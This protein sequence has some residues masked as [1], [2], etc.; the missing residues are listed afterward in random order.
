MNSGDGLKLAAGKAIN[1]HQ[2]IRRNTPTHAAMPDARKVEF[3]IKHKRVRLG[4]V[5]VEG[6]IGR[7][8]GSER[9]QSWLTFRRS[10]FFQLA[11]LIG[12][13]GVS[14]WYWGKWE[15]PAA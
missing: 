1:A 2:E 8:A 13:L 6:S 15:R 3:T 11:V 9:G 14:W 12:Y 5:A 4:A 7:Q 10:K